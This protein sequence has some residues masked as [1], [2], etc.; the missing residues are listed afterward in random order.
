MSALY[1][2]LSVAYSLLVIKNW[3]EAI[4]DANDT[5]ELNPA[6]PVSNHGTNNPHFI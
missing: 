6:N 4:H 5:V 3:K 1:L 2:L